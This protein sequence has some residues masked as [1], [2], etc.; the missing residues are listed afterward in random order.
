I[1]LDRRCEAASPEEFQF[2]LDR[3]AEGTIPSDAHLRLRDAARAFRRR[4]HRRAVIDAGTGVEI[5]LAQFN[6]T[7]TRLPLPKDRSA[8]LGWYIT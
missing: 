8:T 1:V 7:T 5:A 6:R 2:A 4:L 3:V